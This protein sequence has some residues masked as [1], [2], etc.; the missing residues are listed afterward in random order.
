MDSFKVGDGRWDF[1][2]G[3][4]KNTLDSKVELFFSTAE[5]LDEERDYPRFFFGK[6]RQL[7]EE[8]D[9]ELERYAVLARSINTICSAKVE[10]KPTYYLDKHGLSGMNVN[11]SYLMVKTDGMK[12]DIDGRRYNGLVFR[13]EDDYI[14]IERC[15]IEGQKIN[16]YGVIKRFKEDTMIRRLIG[17]VLDKQLV[18]GDAVPS[19]INEMLQEY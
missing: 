5:E 19:Q 8:R 11:G 13:H 17:L 18:K 2:G 16:F 6:V 9:T 4:F 14:V 3:I 10:K 7:D 1:S 15:M 12:R